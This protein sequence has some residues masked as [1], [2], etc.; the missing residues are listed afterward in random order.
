MLMARKTLH[1]AYCVRTTTP[2]G[3][4]TSKTP[5]K[6][7]APQRTHTTSPPNQKPT[8][9]AQADAKARAQMFGGGF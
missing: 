1:T 5:L 7:S 6:K 3:S 4:K 8:S 2:E 9:T